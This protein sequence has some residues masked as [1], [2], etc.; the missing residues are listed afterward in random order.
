MSLDRGE[1]KVRAGFRL[2][3]TFLFPSTKDLVAFSENTRNGPAG[4][5]NLLSTE[6]EYLKL[7]GNDFGVSAVEPRAKSSVMTLQKAHE[8]LDDWLKRKP[9][10]GITVDKHACSSA[11]RAVHPSPRRPSLPKP[12]SEHIKPLVA[13]GWS[14]G[15]IRTSRFPDSC[16]VLQSHP[17]LRRVYSFNDYTSARHFAHAVVAAIPD[18]ALHSF[19]G[20][21]LQM[22]SEI[23]PRL[24]VWSI[25]ELAD[26]PKKYLT[27]QC[28]FCP[29]G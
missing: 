4:D 16:R 1:E 28:A 29:R 23:N 24:K 22:D 2:A 8:M 13:N 15:S 12:T 25:S 14:V 5:V 7:V 18:P 11:P 21:T 19:E 27:Y 3:W 10:R 26:A 9:S 6:T 20:V 17:A